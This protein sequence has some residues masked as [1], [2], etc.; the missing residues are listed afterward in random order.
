MH[1]KYYS[2]ISNTVQV[3]KCQALKFEVFHILANI[4][5]A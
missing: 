2:F 1:F 5:D 4:L 3:K